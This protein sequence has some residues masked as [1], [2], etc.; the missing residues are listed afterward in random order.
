[1]PDNQ[2]PVIPDNPDQTTVVADWRE[3]L[4]PTVKSHPSIQNFK[5][6]GD[7]AKSWVEA[8]K[9]IG[10]DKIPVPGE[11]AT[12][13]D[14]DMVFERL[15]RPKTS[16]GYTLNEVKLPDGLP[17]P[18]EEFIKDFKNKAL[19]LGMLPAQVSQLYDWFMK[20]EVTQY[21]QFMSER[22]S[23]RMQ[24]ENALRK[25]WGKAF[26][27][28][29]QL[30]EQAVVKYGSEE[31]VNKLKSSGLNNDPDMIQFIANIAKNSAEDS[32]AGKA[33]GLTMSPDEAKAEI[34]KIKGEA[35]KDRN[36]PM[37]NKHHPEH[38]L[39]LTKWQHLHEMA[40][41]DNE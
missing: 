8:Q 10:R 26:E 3:G 5:S 39:F 35:M 36:H 15:G 34:A 22:D 7:L 19:E 6:P 31:F 27:Q 24:A 28:N 12:K 21:E 14:W 13:E 11:K 25:A 32:I 18:K 38:E 20:N 17:L 33:S 30:A 29:Y 9:L 37:N 2:D 16:D 41:V 40:F 1:M 23:G 4:D